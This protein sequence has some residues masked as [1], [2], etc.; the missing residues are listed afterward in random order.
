MAKVKGG[1]SEAIMLLILMLFNVNVTTLKY[2]SSITSLLRQR[3]HRI[4]GDKQVNRATVVNLARDE[5]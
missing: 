2:Y 4:R 1:V 3:G 5:R